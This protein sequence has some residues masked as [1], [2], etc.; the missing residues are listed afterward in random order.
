MSKTREAFPFGRKLAGFLLIVTGFLHSFSWMSSGWVAQT[1]TMIVFG[2]ILFAL[3]V[4]LLLAIGK[5]R[6][7]ALL[8]ALIGGVGACITMET[9]QFADWLIWTVI[10]FDIVIFAL[11]FVS[12]WRGRAASTV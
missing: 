3:G 9:S 10:A 1:G 4:G 11:L 12:I 6:Y 5:I 2:Q 7:L 8:A